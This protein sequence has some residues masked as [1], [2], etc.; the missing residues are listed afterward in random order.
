MPSPERKEVR[1][2][3]EEY[4]LFDVAVL[5][6]GF[7]PYM[8]DYKMLIEAGWIGDLAGRYLYRFTHCVEASY[9]T[10][11]HDDVWPESWNDA[12]IDYD[13]WQRAG[14][15]D[16]F[17]WAIRWPLAY[18]GWSYVENSEPARRTGLTGSVRICPKCARRNERIRAVARLPQRRDTEDQRRHGPDTA[19]ILHAR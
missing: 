2:K 11:V 6:H 15:P 7:A 16:V 10:R 4:P 19:G 8:Q 3:L 18:P 9:E 1:E 12:F 17:L 5:S 13:E 14:E